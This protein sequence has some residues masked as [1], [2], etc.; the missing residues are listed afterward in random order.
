MRKYYDD[1]DDYEEETVKIV[2][3]ATLPQ[4]MLGKVDWLL[5]LV[6]GGLVFA[7]LT[8]FPFP[9]LS[10]DV[11]ADAAVAAR[12]RPPA[13]LFPGFW[14]VLAGGFYLG[15]IGVGNL[16]LVW[17]GRLCAAFVA[18]GA[19]LLLRSI[20][21]LLVR[22]RLRFAVRRVPIQR[23]A[24]FLGALAFACS[25]PVWR[26]GQAFGPSGLLV[27]MTIVSVCLFVSFLLNGR[28]ASVSLSMFLLGA[29]ATETPVGFLLLVL[30]WVVYSIALRH[31]ALCERMPL[32][33]PIVG[34]SARWHLTF[35]WALG[36]VLG[37][38]VNCTS[39]WLLRGLEAVSCT[40]WDVPMLYLQRWWGLCVDAAGLMGWI[41]GLGVCVLPCLVA[42]AM[43][44]RAVD[45][46]MF[47]PYHMGAVSFTTGSLAFSQMAMLA[48][49]WFWTWCDDVA[50]RSDYLLQMFMLFAAATL[51]FA[52]TVFGADICCRNHIRLATQRFAELHEDGEA[53]Q[54]IA[55]MSRGKRG[56]MAIFLVV[57]VLLSAGI[58]PGRCLTRTREILQIIEDYA[59]EVVNECGPVRYVFTD[60]WYDPRLELI[61]AERGTTLYAVALMQKLKGQNPVYEQ[62]LRLRGLTDQEDR[63]SMM[64]E[65]ENGGAAKAL[66][67]WMLEKPDRMK[68]AATQLAL[69]FW[70]RDGRALPPCSGVLT[71]PI[72]MDEEARVAGV[73][74]A[75]ALADR[76]L[77]VYDRGGIEKAAG[78]R[79]KDLFLVAQWRISRFA[80]W[81]SKSA[82]WE[83]AKADE[84][85]S[86]NLDKHN[87]ELQKIL[88][89]A[90]RREEASER[91]VTL[92]QSLRNALEDG[93]F[94]R[95]SIAA[96]PILDADPGNPEANFGMAMNHVKRQ[97]WVKAEEYLKRALEAR[98]RQLA[99]WN[100]L[101]MIS[102]KLGNLDEAEARVTKAKEIGPDSVEVMDTARRISDARAV[103]A[104]K[105]AKEKAKREESGNP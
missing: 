12:L 33:D 1:D 103:A 99:Y 102:L 52:L 23:V 25:D 9:A 86:A 7:G 97:E 91:V 3:R 71:R 18:S 74:N 104:G 19:Y 15:G 82:N 36:F 44:P 24:A 69:K 83:R 29:L 8:L 54:S 14:R 60:G 72:G 47:L 6:L 59:Q 93:D 92:R 100:N 70:R 76:I 22:G 80:L 101:A 55:N 64:V 43:L 84:D 90:K 40:A 37:I 75:I 42:A 78:E 39:F 98:P 57:S 79:I 34:Q 49:L 26:A 95:A 28:L 17:G 41:L 4:W 53:A 88:A 73:T 45:E 20:L 63:E 89:D 81:R 61:A 50:M 38:A 62:H 96:G 21:A 10:P 31:A 58:L 68:Q 87:A 85:L 16:C 46:E 48:P 105:A 56:G 32:Q 65:T 51:V 94:I 67:S 2:Q 77:A 5:A 13:D 11:W 66:R 35:F 27:L 30:C